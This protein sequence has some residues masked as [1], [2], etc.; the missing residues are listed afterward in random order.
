MPV[1]CLV[2][3]SASGKSFICDELVKNPLFRKVKA[4]TTRKPRSDGRDAEEY[5][6]VTGEELA[7]A[8]DRND[9][10]EHTTYA[11]H[12]YGIAKSE[13]QDIWSE[14]RI[15]LKP[16]DISGALAC[17]EIYGERCVTIFIRRSKEAIM[18]A[19]LE[20]NVPVEDKVNR[21]I[22]LDTELSYEHLCDWTVSNNGSLDHAIQQVLRIVG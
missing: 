1:V 18:E 11:G 2:G 12:M 20:R 22:S 14:G 6:F 15:A 17:K 19:L 10:V 3:P 9:L 8:I 13:I 7:A 21:L 16:V 4:L 5:K